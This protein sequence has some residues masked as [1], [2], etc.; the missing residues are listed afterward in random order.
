M[1]SATHGSM[2]RMEAVRLVTLKSAISPKQSPELLLDGHASGVEDVDRLTGVS[3][4]EE[5][6]SS[7]HR[8]R[9]SPFEEEAEG[10]ERQP[11]K[12]RNAAQDARIAFHGRGVY[13]RRVRN[14][15]MTT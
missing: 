7:D 8:R 14:V 1:R 15:I 11:T 5:V 3:L 4:A 13:H 9:D 2:A 10:V 12:G 6:V